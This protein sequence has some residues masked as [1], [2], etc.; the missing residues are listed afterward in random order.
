MGSAWLSYGASWEPGFA[1]CLRDI[2]GF[3]AVV[4]P[5]TVVGLQSGAA[6]CV[7]LRGVGSPVLLLFPSSCWL[8]VLVAAGF[9]PFVVCFI[10]VLLVSV[11]GPA[12]LL[13]C[14]FPASG[15]PAV[16]CTATHFL[17]RLYVTHD[18]I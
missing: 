1:W 9:G 5:F 13:E 2:C 14:G 4:V 3:G 11:G 8:M 10:S 7:A 17:L 18:P 6:C 12:S 15:F 16:V